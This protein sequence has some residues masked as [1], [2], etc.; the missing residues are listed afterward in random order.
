MIRSYPN[1]KWKEIDVQSKKGLRYAISNFGRVASFTETIENGILLKCSKTKNYKVFRVAQRIDNKTV[2]KGFYVHKLVAEHFLPKP[3]EIKV[4]VIHKDFDKTNNKVNN[5]QW[6][7]QEELDAHHSKNPTV[8]EQRKRLR[9]HNLK[10]ENGYK[11]SEEKVRI[12][13][14]KLLDPNRRTRIKMIAR[15]FGVSEMQLYR[16]KTGENWAHVKV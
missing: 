16:I 2:S 8:I 6:A 14:R 3:I 12:I 9:E 13:K 1:E 4:V 15:Q 11:L 7:S 10:S 5:L